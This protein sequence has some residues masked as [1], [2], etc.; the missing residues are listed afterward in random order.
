M[1]IS[2]GA[3]VGVGAGSIIGASGGS[4]SVLAGGISGGAPGPL[5]GP[6]L[7]SNEAHYH[8]GHSVQRH[9]SILHRIGVPVPQPYQVQ[10]E[11]RVPVQV[12]AQVAGKKFLLTRRV[13][14]GSN[15]SRCP[16][17]SPLS[18]ARASPL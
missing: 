15:S 13:F 12:S 6:D 5:G 14:K 2:I 11:R 9:V 3:G 16:S 7:H 4:G 8:L 10:V 1:F 17:G 18:S